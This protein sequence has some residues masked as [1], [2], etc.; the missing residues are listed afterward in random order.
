[1]VKVVDLL[2]ES[3]MIRR[4][5][6]KSTI[7]WE[8]AYYS[9]ATLTRRYVHYKTIL[10]ANDEIELFWDTSISKRIIGVMPPEDDQRELV[11]N[12]EFKPKTTLH[13]TPPEIA[14]KKLVQVT[15]VSTKLEYESLGIASI[16]YAT[17][18]A[19]GYAVISDIEQYVPGQG[20][21]KRLA[22][23]HQLHDVKIYVVTKSEHLMKDEHG[24][25]LVYDGENIEDAKIWSPEFNY[26]G[27][28]IL[29]V[30]VNKE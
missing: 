14:A 19:D 18:A 25:P 16:V 27:C 10:V 4:G 28:S 22:K 2:S 1:M 7:D 26:S 3:P 8:K 20:I 29:L 12:L 23:R 11:F 6:M 17:L 15:S 24:Q 9:Q 21:W 30:C 13:S 5:T